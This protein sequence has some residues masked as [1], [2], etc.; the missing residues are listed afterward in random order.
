MYKE[1][2]LSNLWNDVSASAV[3]TCQMS[4]GGCPYSPFDLTLP[5]W[6]TSTTL[7]SPNLLLW[8][9][10]LAFTFCRL[11]FCSFSGQSFHPS[12]QPYVICFYSVSFHFFLLLLLFFP[13]SSAYHLFFLFLS[14]L[15]L[16]FECVCIDVF[17]WICCR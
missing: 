2:P 13:S 1:S 10:S 12:T 5:S 11:P 3:I 17:C 16:L 8:K 14:T 4:P 9:A 6:V 15:V 7:P